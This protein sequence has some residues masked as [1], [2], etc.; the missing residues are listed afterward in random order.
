[1][2]PHIPRTTVVMWW[3]PPL[4]S[5]I[6]ASVEYTA[7]PSDIV[8]PRLEM[9]TSYLERAGLTAASGDLSYLDVGSCY[10]WFVSEMSKRG[11]DAKGIEMDKLALELGP[12]VYG[13]D[14]AQVS[15]GDCITL[16]G[17][18]ARTADVV[19]CFSVLHHFVM[20]R[21]T[22]SAPDL[23]ARLAERTSKVLFLDT[24]QAHESWF[25]WTLPEWSPDYIASWILA[26]SDF[27]RVEAIGVDEDGSGVF[28]GK[29]GRTL[30]A[31]TR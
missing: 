6:A 19:S 24:G 18:Q 13:I 29:F 30:F 11:F 21:G 17:D 16:L 26:H 4:R 20:G 5:D 7:V 3:L 8:P 1:M 10:G 31:C 14:V 27:T 12:L 9:M 25:R 15:V 23:M 2:E 28:R 22:S